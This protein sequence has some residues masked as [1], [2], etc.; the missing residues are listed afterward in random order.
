MANRNKIFIYEKNSPS[1]RRQVNLR[2]VR[3]GYFPR[4]IGATFI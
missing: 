3:T 4:P 1:P 2:F